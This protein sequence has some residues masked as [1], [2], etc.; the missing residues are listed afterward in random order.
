VL[1]E[2]EF[3]NSLGALM[4]TLPVVKTSST[5]P[6]IITGVQGLEPVKADIS[7]VRNAGQDG[8]IVQ[9]VRT[10]SRN[11]VLTIQY[12]PDYAQNHTVQNLRRDLYNYFPPGE[13]VGVRLLIEDS[14]DFEIKGV[15]ETNEPNIF[16]QDPEVQISIFCPLSPFSGLA[17]TT[18]NAMNDQWINP[19][20]LL[21]TAK[22]GFIM[23]LTVT[24]TLPLVKIKNGLNP[25]IVYYR[26][27]IAGDKLA[28]S[29]VPRNKYVRVTR[30]GNTTPDFDG[31][32]SGTLDMIL[33]KRTTAVT[34][35][36]GGAQD[37]AF[38]IMFVPKYLG[39]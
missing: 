6:Y 39:I 38:K 13:D 34:V 29:T 15:V 1:S 37:Q 33:D 36:A 2:I 20:P 22:T 16:S 21:G 18:M 27:L 26:E 35:N 28:I 24:R 17:T 11:I 14:P 7:Y 19:V 23:E 25:D 4:V 10:G 5:V 32:Q 9:A 8:G 3:R 31:I 12:R 30:S